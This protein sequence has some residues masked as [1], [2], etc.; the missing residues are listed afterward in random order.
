MKH[1]TL[2]GA[3]ISAV[4]ETVRAIGILVGLSDLK[5]HALLSIVTVWGAAWMVYGLRKAVGK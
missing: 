2:Q 4:S 1:R 5:V 3:V